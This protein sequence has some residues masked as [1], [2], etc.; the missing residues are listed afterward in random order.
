MVAPPVMT[1][2]DAPTPTRAVLLDPLSIERLLRERR[3]TGAHARDE[4]W[5]GVLHVVPGPSVEHQNVLL[6]LASILRQAVAHPS[7]GLAIQE[8]NT[9]DP[10]RELGDFRIPDVVVLLPGSIPLLKR[11]LFVAG[12]P[13][14]VVEVRSPGD[15]TDEKVPFYGRIGVR[16]L[17]VVDAETKRVELLRHDGRMLSRVEATPVESEVVRLRFETVER[18][19]RPSLL[20]TARDGR[21]WEVRPLPLPRGE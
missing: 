18:G 2:V 14:L 4:V 1:Q 16:E 7:G 17:L 6:E 13:D 10:V 12:G 8:L 21:T 15:E 5:E 19:G 11:G 20:V 3:R 9:A